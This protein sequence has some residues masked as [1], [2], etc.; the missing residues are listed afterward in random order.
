M[1]PSLTVRQRVFVEE[2]VK[3][4]EPLKA[5]LVAYKISA[6]ANRRHVASSIA[7]QNLRNP[8]VRAYMDSFYF[9]DMELVTMLK[10]ALEATRTVRGA[11]KTEADWSVRLRALQLI[12][13]LKGYFDKDRLNNNTRNSKVYVK[14]NRKKSKIAVESWVSGVPDTHNGLPLLYKKI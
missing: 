3:T 12:F 4:R 11:G 6:T 1:I 10:N 2:M 9:S 7:Y 14:F 13:T 5:A 8:R